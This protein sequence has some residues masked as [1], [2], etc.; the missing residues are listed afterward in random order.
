MKTW[1]DRDVE[2]LIRESAFP[3]PAHKSSLRKQLF[4]QDARL[5]LDDLDAVAGGVRPPEPESP[6]SWAAW[7]AAGEDRT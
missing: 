4:E 2:N 1:T 6:E 5:D 7:P 3:N